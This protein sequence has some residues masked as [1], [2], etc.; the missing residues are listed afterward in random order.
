MDSIF[1]IFFNGALSTA[2]VLLKKCELTGKHLH[3]S[4]LLLISSRPEA[5]N[6]MKKETPEQFF[7]C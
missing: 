6:F 2:G 5:Y 7:A 1:L 3:R 4:L